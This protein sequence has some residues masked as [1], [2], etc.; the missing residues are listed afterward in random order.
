MAAPKEPTPTADVSPQQRAQELVEQLRSMGTKATLDGMARYNIPS[1]GAL[2]VPMGALLKMAKTLGTQH[3]LAHA[4]W[5]AGPYEARTLAALVADPAQLTPQHM[6]RWCKQFDN[7]AICDT[8]CFKLFDR[9]KHAWAKVEAW[10]PQPQEFVRR[11]AFALLWGLTVHDKTAADGPFLR[12]L[13][14]VER[15]ATDERNFVKKA[16]NMALRA[17]GKRNATLHAAAL[18]TSRRLA[19]SE[20]ATAQWIGKDALRELQ[21]ASV[22]RRQKPAVRKRAPR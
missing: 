12:G 15:A 14:L 19:E 7:W 5:D 9:S 13:E 2:G 1:Q 10:A 18:A 21:S 16:V 22:L 11:A 20:N 6:E 8:V 3:T 4:L 17:V